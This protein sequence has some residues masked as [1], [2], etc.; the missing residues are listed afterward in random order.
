LTQPCQRGGSCISK[1]SSY[2]CKC[3]NSVYGSNCEFYRYKTT[4]STI[5]SENGMKKLK[6]LINVSQ[7]QTLKMIYQASI[8]GFSN[9]HS[10]CNG[11]LGTLTIIKSNSNSNSSENIFG[12][13]TEQDW[14]GYGQYKNDPFAFL[15]SLVNT[16]KISVKMPVILPQSAIYTYYNYY[17]PSFGGGNDLYINGDGSAGSSNLG[18]T[19]Q[20]PSFLTYG[21]ASAQSFLAGSNNF[22]PIEIEV[23]SIIIDRNFIHFN[24]R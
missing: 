20:L 5:L 22:K 15:F 17:G 3:I 12:G 2:T 1:G 16:Y 19:Y 10:K 24:F 9:F 8:D 6:T 11:V 23:Y 13:Y 4:N 18:H 21:T 14:S 7:N